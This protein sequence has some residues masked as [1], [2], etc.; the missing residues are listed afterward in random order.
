[1][2]NYRKF[3]I[4]GCGNL[5]RIKVNAVSFRRESRKEHEIRK[6]EIFYDLL[7]IG[8]NFITEAER[9]MKRSE[10][11]VAVDIVDLTTGD[12]YEVETSKSRSKGLI[13]EGKSIVSMVKMEGR[14]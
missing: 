5:N 13:S 1:M 3:H 10:A 2:E 8:H 4:R 14:K 11:R 12:E 6:A 7:A 9:N